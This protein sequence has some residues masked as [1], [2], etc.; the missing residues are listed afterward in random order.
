MPML[1]SSTNILDISLDELTAR[2]SAWG[3]PPYRAKQVYDWI[4]RKNAAS[5]AAMTSLSKGLRDKLSAEL[6]FPVFDEE[7]RRVSKDGTVK[8]LW[9]LA[10]GQPA[11]PA[12]QRGERIE[13]VLI[14]MREHNTLCISSQSGCKFACRFCASGL[15]G[16][17]RNL[18]CG[19][20]IG[21]VLNARRLAKKPVTHIV[22]M[23]IGEPFDN[24][25]NVLRAVRVLNA[26]D[27]FNIAARRIT[28]STCGIVPGIKRLAGEGLQIE[29]SV[30]LHA[31]NDGL[32][33]E[34]MPVNRKYPLRELIA[35]CRS[36]AKETNRQV[37]FEYI[38]I[39]DVTVTRQGVLELGRLLSGWLCK[40]NL[41]VYNPV[42]EFP[43]A[44]PS[45]DAIFE[46]KKKLEAQGVIVTFR[47]PKGQ[48]IEAACGQLRNALKGRP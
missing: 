42:A 4:Y 35:A 33:N 18:S 24:Y 26:K 13:S 36:Y 3:E 46:F 1:P 2:F 44:A 16:W 37:T 34:L 31:S 15:G 47:T 11:A 19:E 27:G 40:L 29:L 32:R 10:D 6:P 7:A 30:S 22:F 9:S 8:F 5:Y 21:Q 28:L 48:D 12:R 23:G 17:R 43:Y 45:R 20:I 41:I 38:L 39:K 25:E 14:P